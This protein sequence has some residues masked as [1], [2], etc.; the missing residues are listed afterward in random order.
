MDCVLQHFHWFD[1]GHSLFNSHDAGFCGAESTAP[2]GIDFVNATYSYPIR[3]GR[4]AT[5][6]IDVSVK[7]M[8]FRGA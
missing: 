3:H 8:S 5:I 7:G 2:Q 4:S 6:N 1:G